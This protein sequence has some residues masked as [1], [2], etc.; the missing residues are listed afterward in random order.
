MIF[1]S[2]DFNLEGNFGADFAWYRT[3]RE[4]TSGTYNCYDHASSHGLLE[5]KPGCFVNRGSRIHIL[6]C[7]NFLMKQTLEVFGL[8]YEILPMYR[9]KTSAISLRKNPVLHT[10]AKHIELLYHFIRDNIQKGDISIVF[11]WTHDQPA[12]I[13]RP[14][15]EERLCSISRQRGLGYLYE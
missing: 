10:R 13:T 15:N 14:L 2:I 9:D 3:D 12:D 4:C 8:Y 11:I 1:Y 7:P 5:A 6:L